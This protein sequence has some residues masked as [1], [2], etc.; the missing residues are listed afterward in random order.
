MMTTLFQV[1][2]GLGLFLFGMKI[3]S[4]GLQKVAG[5]KMRQILGMVSNNRFVGCG[6][7]ALVTSVVQSS[8]AITVMLVGFVDAGL[9]TLVQ[10]TGVILGANIGT[11]VTAQLIAFNITEYALP[12]IASGVLFKFFLGRRKWIYVGDVLLGFGL[13]FY[14]LGTMKAGFAPLKHDPNF[15]ALL[16]KFDAD[17]LGRILLCIMAGTAMTMVLQSSS[18]TVGIIMAL[19][20]Q[21]L[22][23]FETSAGLVLGT[24]IGTTVTAQ[25][26]ALGANI[27]AHRTATTHSLVNVIGVFIV[28]LFFPLFLKLVVWLT[29]LMGMG[30]PD[31]VI[32]G[33]RPNIARYIANFQTI[34]NV[35]TSL[36][37]LMI[38]PYVVKAAIWLTPGKEREEGLDELHHVKYMDSKF[39]EIPSMALEQASLEI[40]RM[41]EA[42]QLMYYEV[43]QSLEE[44]DT[45]KLSKWGKREDALDILQREITLFLVRVMQ[46]RISP[47]ESKEVRSLIRMT[48]N[49]ERIGDATGDIAKLI[50][51][52]IEQNLYLS[53]DAIRDYQELSHETLKFLTLVV[54]AMKHGDEEIM[55]TSRKIEG[56]IMR[57]AEK[58]K[59]SHLYRLQSGV[60]TVDSGL[61]FVKILTA[62]ERMGKFCYNI[63]QAVTGVR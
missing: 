20:S 7:G 14:G 45:K 22:L 59:E 53:D 18:A 43:I 33:Q 57:M 32:G 26:A 29:S 35:I 10:A 1:L 46:G 37:F 30:P 51:E 48:N 5:K 50:D 13:V 38:L 58:M 62:F 27:N 39:V 2:G 31:V 60:C 11:T 40:K 9:I 17:N 8:S 4:E 47:E 12:A 15:V 49:L 63:S 41:G 61:I 52:L 28:I 42:V 34:F 19:A 55:A 36:S 25:I 23:N 21:G 3:M 6:V 54:N 44:R 56:N 24:E 16:T